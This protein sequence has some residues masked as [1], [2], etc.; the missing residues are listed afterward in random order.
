MLKKVGI[1]GCGK[2]F[3]AH[4]QAINYNSKNFSL[5]AV[6]DTD[7]ERL[8]KAHSDTGVSAFSKLDSMLSDMQGKMDTVVIATPNYLHYSQAINALKNNYSIIIEKPISFKAK[9]VLEIFSLAKS[10]NLSADAVLQVRYNESVQF[11]KSAIEKSLLG[12]I[13][14]ASLIQRWQRPPEYFQ[15][16]R[17]NLEVGGGILYEI[18]IH[19]LDVMQWVIGEVP[20]VLD[21]RTFNTKY[22]KIAVEDILFSLV[23]FKNGAPGSIEVSLAA[24][25]SNLECSLAVLGENGY[26]KISGQ[27]MN[28]VEVANFEDNS[29]E[30]KKLLKTLRK[31]NNADKTGVYNYGNHLGS[32]PNHHILYQKISQGKGISLS[33]AVNSIDL[34]EKIYQ[35]EEKN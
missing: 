34:I 4:F 14:S 21:T 32:S 19:Y 13:R 2:I 35:A 28:K 11:L 22:K 30:I 7:K 25:P 10:K 23:V 16:W 24:V 33:E 12:K 1:V 5:V 18:G 8:K 20:G 26:I 27:T 3:Q 31:I 15:S 9:E 29:P 6:C 17:G